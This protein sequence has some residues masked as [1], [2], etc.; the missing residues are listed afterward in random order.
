MTKNHEGVYIAI[1]GG[2]GSGKGTQT[3]ELVQDLTEQGF[4]VLATTYPQYGKPSARYVERYLRGE[5]G[6]TN[7]V[8]AGL[9]SL[10]Y[11]LDRVD[12]ETLSNVRAHLTR[13]DGVVVSD[14]SPASNMGHQGTKLATIDER[15]A[16]YREIIELEYDV[17]REPRPDLS[18]VLRVP[19]NVAQANVDAKDPSIRS[20]TTAKRDI[21]EEDANHLRLALRGY[22]E[23]C[24]LLPDEF[25]A[26]D[27]LD[28]AGNMRPVDEV[29]AQIMELIWLRGLLPR[30]LR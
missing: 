13:P 20:Y 16:F 29:H 22:N 30:K 1:E 28:I 3:R 19:A 23:L 17:L 18:I 9:A 14:R 25:T 6:A 26:I 12:Y 2:D 15:H 11:A 24:D 10:A 4:D 5:Y 21:H 27:A 7:D 8:P